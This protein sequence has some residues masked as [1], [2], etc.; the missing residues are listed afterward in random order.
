MLGLSSYILPCLKY[1]IARYRGS[2][3]PVLSQ[4]NEREW[5]ENTPVS[6]GCS[7]PYACLSVYEGPHTHLTAPRYPCYHVCEGWLRPERKR[8]PLMAALKMPSADM[9]GTRE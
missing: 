6:E 7:P 2:R 8:D 9:E 3:T 1:L 5:T 4:T